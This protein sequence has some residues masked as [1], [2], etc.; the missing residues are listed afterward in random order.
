MKMC[1]VLAKK[2]LLQDKFKAFGHLLRK[3]LFIVGIYFR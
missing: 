2:S 3:V 1:V